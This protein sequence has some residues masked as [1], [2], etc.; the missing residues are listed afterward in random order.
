MFFPPQFVVIKFTRPNA[1]I[2]GEP[3]CSN[4]PDAAADMSLCFASAVIVKEIQN[5]A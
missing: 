2:C 3:D 4:Y 1:M 5:L